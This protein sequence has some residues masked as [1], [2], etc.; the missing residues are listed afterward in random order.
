MTCPECGGELELDR[1]C[2]IEELVYSWGKPIPRKRLAAAVL[3]TCCEYCAELRD[4][5]ESNVSSGA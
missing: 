5:N 1:C 3:C 2:V 4:H